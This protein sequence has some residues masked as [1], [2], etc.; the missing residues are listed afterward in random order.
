MGPSPSSLY[1]STVGQTACIKIVGRANLASSVDFKSLIHELR[2]RKFNGFLIDLGQCATMDS[3]FLGVLAGFA[4]KFTGA[5]GD[6][7]RRLSL[8]NPNQRI[9]ELLENLGVSQLF[10]VHHQPSPEPESP[11]VAVQDTAPSREQL[12]RVC[13]EAHQTLMA[14]NP[15]NIPKFK[16]VAQFLAED[17]KRSKPGP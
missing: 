6:G 9:V 7:P 5:A 1:V 2:E 4:L 16:D 17:L 14:V 12:S 11:E 10:E 8:L 15:D 13:L 3:T